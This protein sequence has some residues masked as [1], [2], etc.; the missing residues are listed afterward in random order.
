MRP[1]QPISQRGLFKRDFGRPGESIPVC[2]TGESGSVS[3]QGESSRDQGRHE[4]CNEV[5]REP[6]E[7]T[8][9]ELVRRS[10]QQAD[11][12]GG[13]YRHGEY[14]YGAC[15]RR[16][17]ER[18]PKTFPQSQRLVPFVSINAPGRFPEHARQMSQPCLFRH[19]VA[20]HAVCQQIFA[21][22]AKQSDGS[23]LS[24][25]RQ[26]FPYLLKSREL[27]LLAASHLGRA[28]LLKG[29]KRCLPSVGIS[30]HSWSVRPLDGISPLQASRRSRWSEHK[31][32]DPPGCVGRR[33][34]GC[35]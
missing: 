19:R 6:K 26:F 17:V 27:R 14:K 30:L 24:A 33:F 16:Q 12:V 21:I 11:C 2:H 35:M 32:Q 25:G 10:R 7:W 1:R 23:N 29:Y 3:H 4:V 22:V 9:Y 13:T 28:N 34:G 18:I 8:K 20:M 5:E 31:M 15:D